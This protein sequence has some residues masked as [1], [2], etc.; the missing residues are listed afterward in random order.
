MKE[1]VELFLKEWLSEESFINAHSSGSTGTPKPIRLPKSL[2][3]DSALRTIEFFKIEHS[4]R[5]HLCLSTDYI[6]GK[7]M[8]VRSQ[9]SGAELTV[10]E[11]SNTP[12]ADPRLREGRRITLLAIVPSQ[13]VSLLDNPER[14]EIVDNILLGGS[15]I[16]TELRK[17]F[18]SMN[19]RVKAWE[20]YGM[21]E[22]ASHIALRPINDSETPFT[23]LPGIRCSLGEQ[24]NL[25]IHLGENLIKTRD[26]ATLLSPTSF[27]IRGRL[28]NVIISGGLKIHPE[29]LEIKAADIL[30]SYSSFITG[31]HDEKWGEIP[32]LAI[33]RKTTLSEQE[34]K[35]LLMKL[36]ERLGS[37]MAPKKIIILPEFL[38]TDSGKV[39]R[40]ISLP[41]HS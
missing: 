15:P 8:V 29:E 21:T 7:M 36:R 41:L 4:S 24:E 35:V 13:L 17:L 40:K 5:L 18:L 9:M 28:D 2:V 19:L 27:Y 34:E 10:E 1:D 20:S 30:A 31:A 39:I 33:E 3:R 32:V 37:K 16:P 25:C 26:I 11:P 12:L 23:C 22:T 6:A 38:R 14:L